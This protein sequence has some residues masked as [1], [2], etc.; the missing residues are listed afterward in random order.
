[1]RR[2]ADVNVQN[3]TKNALKILTLI[4]IRSLGAKIPIWNVK[5]NAKGNCKSR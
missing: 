1:M 2:L 4:E 3:N 5:I